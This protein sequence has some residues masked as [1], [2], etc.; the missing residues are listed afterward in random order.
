MPFPFL[1]N[2]TRVYVQFW[3]LDADTPLTAEPGQ[4][5]DMAPVAGWD[6]PVPPGDGRWGPLTEPAVDLAEEPEVPA[7]APEPGPEPAVPDL[8]PV[9]LITAPAETEES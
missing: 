6:M 8:P 7:V 3:D 1:G 9:P 5:Y 4:S 2:S